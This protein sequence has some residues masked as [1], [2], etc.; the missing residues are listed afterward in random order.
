MRCQADSMVRSIVFRNRSVVNLEA[1]GVQVVGQP[2]KGEV[3]SRNPRQQP[4]PVGANNLL[5]PITAN[6]GRC[7]APCLP[8][9]GHPFDDT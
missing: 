4:L 2:L 8:V 5:W 1:A 6:L 9:P 7:N 3:S